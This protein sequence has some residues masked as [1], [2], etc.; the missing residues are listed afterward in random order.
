MANNYVDYQIGGIGI[1]TAAQYYLDYLAAEKNYQAQ[2]ETNEM[3]YKIHKEN[4]EWNR[5]VN[6]MIRLQEAGLNPLLMY[7]HGNTG[8]A[9]AMP[10]MKAPQFNFS[11]S[12]SIERSMAIRNLREQNRNLDSQNDLIESQSAA[13]A[14]NAR[15]TKLENDFFEKH[16]YWPGQEV[17]FMRGLRAGIGSVPGMYFNFVDNLYDMFLASPEELAR[18]NKVNWNPRG[19]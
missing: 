12:A 16:G 9:T 13:A 2:K 18:K 19:G 11:P 4:L 15:R 10:V 14:E 8:N 6:Q 3:N 17:G 5:P 1:D 7:N